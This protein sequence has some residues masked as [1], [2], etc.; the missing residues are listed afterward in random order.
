VEGHLE[1]VAEGGVKRELEVSM[2][3]RVLVEL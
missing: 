1:V 2:V 3:T